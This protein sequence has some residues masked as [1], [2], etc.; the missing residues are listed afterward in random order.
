MSVM[1]LGLYG[2]LRMLLIHNEQ[3]QRI[4]FLAPPLQSV[5]YATEYER[6]KEYNEDASKRL[7]FAAFAVCPD[8]RQKVS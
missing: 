4:L 1:L 2:G 8:K 3:K 7:L 6:Q 5:L